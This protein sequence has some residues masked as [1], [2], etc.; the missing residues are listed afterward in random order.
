MSGL[1]YGLQWAGGDRHLHK[2]TGSRVHVPWEE[3][4]GGNQ[5]YSTS[6]R[7]R[8]RKKRALGLGRMSDPVPPVQRA[9][10]GARASKV[11]GGEGVRKRGRIRLIGR[12]LG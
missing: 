4:W 12:D 6:R 9:F 1:S 3:G 2:S 11:R 8:A 7:R 10:S 5:C